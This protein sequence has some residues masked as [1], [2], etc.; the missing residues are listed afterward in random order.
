VLWDLYRR[1]F[2]PEGDRLLLVAQGETRTFNPTLPQSVID[3]AME[4]DAA[5]ATAEYLA[6]FPIPL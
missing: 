6:Q 5:S 3:R 2:G 4:R 1:Q